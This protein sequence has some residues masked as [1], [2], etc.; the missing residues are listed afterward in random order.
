MESIKYRL[1]I[2]LYDLDGLAEIVTQQVFPAVEQA[3]A[4]AAEKIQVTWQAVVMKA[5][6]VYLG[7][8]QKYADSIQWKM[9]GPMSALIWTDEEVS[10]LVEEGFPA[11]DQK[12]YLQTSNKTRVNKKGQKYLLIPFR[13]NTPGNA[14][15]AAPM[16][17][18]IYEQA[19][20]MAPSR[21]TGK[22]TRL[23]ATGA[24]V[25]QSIYQWGGRLPAGLAPKKNASH[26]TDIYAGM[27]KFNTSSGG[28][29]SSAYLTFRVMR[30]DQQGKW[31]LP[32]KPGLYLVRDMMDGIHRMVEGD[33]REAISKSVT[34]GW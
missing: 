25:P 18:H 20:A 12:R 19:K 21:V 1:D 32:A 13:H 22:T 8:K 23:S 33:L 3:I 15:H 28:Q 6:G 30:E 27:V 17:E 7:A 29:K 14:A 11:F 24:T 5:P 4:N 16:P 34:S 31:I 2:K 9:V 26:T 10:R